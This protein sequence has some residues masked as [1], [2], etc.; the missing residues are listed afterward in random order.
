MI[1]LVRQEEPRGCV[2][3][4]LAM[5]AGCRYEDVRRDIDVDTCGVSYEHANGWLAERGFAVRTAQRAMLFADVHLAT[6]QTTMPHAVVVLRDGT[7]LDPALDEP[8]RFGEGDYA[9]ERVTRVDGFYRVDTADTL[10]PRPSS[11]EACQ[12]AASGSEKHSYTTRV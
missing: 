3:A 8:G 7:V 4:C 10:A 9:A 11:G 1:R 2:I 6:F 5:I 12:T